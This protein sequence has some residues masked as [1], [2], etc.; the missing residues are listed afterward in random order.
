MYVS[1]IMVM[2]HEYEYL[3]FFKIMKK[4]TRIT[5]QWLPRSF[6]KLTMLIVL[7]LFL[8]LTNAW[9]FSRYA[10][11]ILPNIVDVEKILMKHFLWKVTWISEAKKKRQKK[12]HFLNLWK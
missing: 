8:S 12:S 2:T 9:V 10:L 3:R 6:I 4:I 11:N 7:L 5:V 1:Q